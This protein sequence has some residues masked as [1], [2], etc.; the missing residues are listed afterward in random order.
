MW[1]EALWEVPPTAGMPAHMRDLLPPWRDDFAQSA[2]NFLDVP[3][4]GLECSGSASLLVI[5][6]ALQ[7]LS[8]RR[9]VIVPA[10]TCPLVVFAVAQ[11]GLQIKIC[12]LAPDSFELDPTALDAACDD[13][14][15]AIIP[16]HLAG[17]VAQLD[18]VLTIA[19]RHGAYVIE[20]AAQAF[21]AKQNGISVGLSGDAGFFSFAPGKGLGLYEGG[22]WIARDPDLHA[23]INRV[24]TALVPLR[25]LFEALRCAQLAGYAALYRPLPLRFIYGA[26][27]RRALRR[28]DL[29][30][31]AGDIFSANIPLHRVGSWRRTAG[32]R[33]LLRLPDFQAALKLQAAKRLPPLKQLRKVKVFDD[34]PGATGVWPSFLLLMPT[35][36]V[37]D[38]AL[39][40]LWGSGKGVTR[41]F[42]HA[43]PDYDYL[44]PLLA[45][46]AVP[47][48]RDFAA[49]SFTISNSP[50]LDDRR[51]AQ[52]VKVL[53][54]SL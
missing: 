16:T 23:T 22:M 8:E 31:A 10:Y 20:D 34:A 13:E 37:R 50:W 52:I 12:D 43:L 7:T 41:M 35:Q 44:L 9:T 19:K 11:C 3:G 45:P 42:A 2:A 15:L 46:A 48:A 36:A 29:I 28:H 54:E 49:R 32:S 24:S 14:T 18:D 5:L 6:H 17:R 51:F 4:A 25:C 53:Q 21:G 47:N 30:A 38:A 40:R 1:A 39:S 33:A 27:L 26:P